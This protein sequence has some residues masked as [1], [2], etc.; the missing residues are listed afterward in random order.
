MNEIIHL[1]AEIGVILL[2]FDVGL[3][4]DLG[5]LIK[6]GKSS[7]IVALGGFIAPFFAACILG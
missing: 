6:T 4:T 3:E 5:R 7:L 1:L 2:L